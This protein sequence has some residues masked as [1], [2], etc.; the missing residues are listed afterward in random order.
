MQWKI[1]GCFFLT[2]GITCVSAGSINFCE[3]L[4]GAPAQIGYAMCIGK[5]QPLDFGCP[6][7]CVTRWTAIYNGCYEKCETERIQKNTGKNSSQVA[8][9]P[10]PPIHFKVPLKAQIGSK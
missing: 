4:C 7:V 8:R 5:C 1:I 3:E 9:I 2:L 6:D 10:R